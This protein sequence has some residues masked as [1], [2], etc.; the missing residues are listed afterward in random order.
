MFR[1]SLVI[2]ILLHVLSGC[3]LRES[4]IMSLA[5]GVT[6][7]FSYGNGY[8]LL[9]D[10]EWIKITF[11]G[12]NTQIELES[13][14]TKFLWEISFIT[15]NK[16][17]NS[18]AVFNVTRDNVTVV[19]PQIS[20]GAGDSKHTI[21]PPVGKDLLQ[22]LKD[23]SQEEWILRLDFTTVDGLKS[24]VYQPV[25]FDNQGKRSTYDFLKKEGYLDPL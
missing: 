16:S 24:S 12:L 14:E 17:V 11:A 7:T 15:K 10:H 4:R 19:A 1:K 5:D 18:V 21:N 2:I 13:K 25:L 9:T 23:E 6:K 20:L 22:F 8:P 3:V